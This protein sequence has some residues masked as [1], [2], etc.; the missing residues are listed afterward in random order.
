M[1]L[2]D[3]FIAKIKGYDANIEITIY[4]TFPSNSFPLI[5]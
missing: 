2:Y 5:M 3:R 1:I 4:K